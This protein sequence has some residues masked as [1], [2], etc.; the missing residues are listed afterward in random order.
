MLGPSRIMRK[1]E[2][3][4]RPLTGICSK[5]CGSGLE[6][7]GNFL[8][9]GLWL[10]LLGILLRMLSHVLPLLLLLLVPMLHNRR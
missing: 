9:L 8:S 7:V 3:L 6:V 2:C 1:S 4:V 10:L 5:V